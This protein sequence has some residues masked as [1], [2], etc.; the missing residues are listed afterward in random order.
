MKLTKNDLLKTALLQALAVPLL[1][2]PSFAQQEID[3][4]WHD[5]WAVTS[6]TSAQ[7][8]AA[9][10]AAKTE[11]PKPSSPQ[12]ASTHK[13]PAA[14]QQASANANSHKEPAKNTSIAGSL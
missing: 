12:T 8:P 7:H 3:P 4:T 9:K 6:P 14:K 11:K 2:A 1:L 13:K 10:L 5:P